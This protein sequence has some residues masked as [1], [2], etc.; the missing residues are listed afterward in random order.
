MIFLTEENNDDES[1]DLNI[2]LAGMKV[3]GA[4]ILEV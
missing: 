3:R 1:H 2:M 4:G